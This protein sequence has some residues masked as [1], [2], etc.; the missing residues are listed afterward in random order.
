ASERSDCSRWY[1]DQ[2]CPAGLA[3]AP[4]TQ[5]PKDAVEDATIIHPRHAAR[6][7]RQH[8]VDGSPLVF[9]AHDSKLPV[10][11]FES[12]ASGQPQYGF[13]SFSFLAKVAFWGQGHQ[14]AGTTG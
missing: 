10:W 3:K 6:L 1:A 2:N 13:R 4:R 7:A 14:P 11:E 9:V 5:Y 8:R 12:Q